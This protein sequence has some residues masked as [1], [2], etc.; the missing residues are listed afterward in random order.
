MNMDNK[1]PIL[2]IKDLTVSFN[3]FAGTV[4]AVRG[5]SLE[6]SHGETLAI[7][8][9]SGS[10]KSVT[11]KAVMGL[12]PRNAKIEGGSI[13]F[14]GENITDYSEDQFC[15]LRGKKISI[16]F[17]DPLSS[18]N[19]IM[20]IGKQIMEALIL[21]RGM[22]KADARDK[23]LELMKAV[24]IPEP[25]TR[26]YQY[27]FQFSGGMRQRIVIAIALASDPEIL[28]CDEPTTALDV[29]IQARILELIKDI[30]RQRDLSIIFIT[31][32]LGVVANLADKVAVMYAGRI[33]E[34]GTAKDI[35][36]EP[37]NPYTWALL[38]SMPDM[39][40]KEALFSIP[41]APPDMI[42]P[43]KGDAFSMRNKYALNI[44][45]EEEPPMFRVTDTHCAATWLLHPNAPK[46]D[47]PEVLRHRIER[48]KEVNKLY[49]GYDDLPASGGE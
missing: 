32:D 20:K 44:D 27:P 34:Y 6:L 1:N 33:V 24:G 12:L 39:E 7:V 4:K 9:E 22:K 40:T 5:V 45:F 2:E 30:K 26:F 18:L 43:P 10:G 38:S 17:Q 46:M 31:H 11:A 37:V 15:G 35:F 8:G 25:E 3:A 16:V 48:L 42:N 21:S 29:T 14:H 28:I 41:G 23:A 49:D 36:Y 47:M 19:P 13:L